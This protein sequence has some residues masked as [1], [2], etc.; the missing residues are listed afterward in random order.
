MEDAIND[1][2]SRYKIKKPLDF[3]I[4]TEPLGNDELLPIQDEETKETIPI[5]LIGEIVVQKGQ[6]PKPS[7]FSQLKIVI[8]STEGE[9]LKEEDSQ[10]IITYNEV[11]HRATRKVEK[12]SRKNVID[13]ISLELEQVNPIRI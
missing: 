6:K 4:I 7:I 1:L 12:L 2:S 11:I 9:I 8:E 3:I 5:Y 10:N 13:T